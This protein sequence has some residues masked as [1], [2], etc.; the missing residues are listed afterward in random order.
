MML[1]RAASLI[2][3][4][5]RAAALPLAA[6]AAGWV[7]Y[8]HLGIDHAVDLPPAIDAPRHH[9]HTP[10]GELAYYA[11]DSAEGRPLVL[12]HSINAAAS[13]YEMRPLFERYRGQRPVYAL[14]LP[15]FGASERGPRP[16][17][18]ELYRE[19][20][21]ALLTHIGAPA[22]VI[23]LSLTAEF[24]ALAAHSHPEAFHSLTLIS[25]TGL[26]HQS[27]Q[28]ATP[29]ALR[30]HRLFTRDLLRQP[31]Y[32]L[33]VTRP[34]LRYFLGQHFTGER[35]EELVRYAFLTA[36]RPGA[37]YAPLAFISG[38]LFTPRVFSEIYA[39]IHV[40]THVLYDED[41]HVTFDRLPELLEKSPNWSATR[42]VPT[43]G[44][45]H[46][47]K[48]PAAAQAV[49]A[50]WAALSADAPAHES[51]PTPDIDA[52]PAE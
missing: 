24:A 34:S 49:D 6:A 40:P 23:A 8:S 41:P 28:G 39:Q 31:L 12:L 18:P 38:L 4:G 43:R 10:S 20:I 2:G 47:D 37:A 25:P 36:H 46:W 1:L 51:T 21:A 45:P 16:Y 44:L 11:D 26:G 52:T 32:D 9:L 30:R 27:P 17:S 19:A 13:A 35:P 3:L 7:T 33:V 29:A 50:F 22:D 5:A 15:G 14:D 48:L 42:I